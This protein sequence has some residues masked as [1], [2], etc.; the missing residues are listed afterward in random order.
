M[1]KDTSPS[2]IQVVL[3]LKRYLGLNLKQ[4]LLRPIVTKSSVDNIVAVFGVCEGE[5]RA[6]RLP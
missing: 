3:H 4:I 1:S 2:N 6:H 5:F